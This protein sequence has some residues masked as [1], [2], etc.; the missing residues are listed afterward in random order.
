MADDTLLTDICGGFGHLAV[1]TW[2]PEIQWI[3]VSHAVEGSD[4]VGI[5]CLAAVNKTWQFIVESLTFRRIRVSLESQDQDGAHHFLSILTPAR[6]AH[7]K[8]LIVEVAWPFYLS[9]QPGRRFSAP[10]AVYRMNGTIV[11][12]SRFIT[13]L[14]RATTDSTP[15]GLNLVLKAI[16]PAFVIPNYNISNRMLYYRP[17][18]PA[19]IQ[20]S[21][22]SSQMQKISPASNFRWSNKSTINIQALCVTLPIVTG[23]TFPPDFFHPL[24]IPTFLSRFPN[25]TII[26]LKPMCKMADPEGWYTSQSCP[27]FPS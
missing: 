27:C 8:E 14:R 4:K 2:A 18:T 5:G 3:I 20:S 1:S 23:L 11:F 25:L 22:L 21:W 6:L 24:A 13:D 16:K 10:A 7:L 15:S 12:L 19:E 9:A 17:R 26:E